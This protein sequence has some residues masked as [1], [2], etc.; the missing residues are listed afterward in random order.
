MAELGLYALLF[1]ALSALLAMIDAAVLSVT[2]AESEELVG[3]IE[4][5]QDAA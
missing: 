4:D 3:E 5:T 2:R 1:I